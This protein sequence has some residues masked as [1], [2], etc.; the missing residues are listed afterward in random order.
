MSLEVLF[1]QHLDDLSSRYAAALRAHGFERLVIHSGAAAPQ[2]RF[3]DQYW[4][5]R[6]TPYFAHWLPLPEAGAFAVVTPGDP[7]RVHR[8]AHES[9]WDSPALRDDDHVWKH[10]ACDKGG[11]EAAVAQVSRRCAFIGEDDDAGRAL[12]FPDAALNPPELL[13]ELDRIRAHKTDYERHCIGEANRIAALGHVAAAA[14][15]A[16][17]DA[18]ELELQHAYLAATEQDATETPYGNIVA[19]GPNASVLH[20]VHYDRRHR[21]RPSLLVDAG[22]RFQGYASDIT[23]T[24]VKHSGPGPAAT[25]A[26]LVAR[27]DAL[28]TSLC[29]QARPG[30]PYET[31]HERAHH[32][33]AEILLELELCQGSADALVERGVTRTFFPHGLGHSL[34]IQVHDVGCKP[35]PPSERNPHLRTTV[36][37]EVGHV[38]TIEPGCYFI[39]ALL[40]ALEASEHGRVVNWPLVKAL[41]GFGGVRIEDDVAVGPD[42]TDNLTRDNWPEEN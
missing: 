8:S 12:G 39:P 24:W 3:D 28:Q 5:H 22:A 34:G 32:G 35:S 40:D 16:A 25:F 36:T 6:P 2:S 13:A 15:F 42:T 38:L 17:G 7:L 14:L 21:N 41:R 19:L 20:H 18:T 1:G 31:L 37:I 11:A 27:M 29:Q 9:F 30:L 23:R 4:P 26:A 10:V 33:L